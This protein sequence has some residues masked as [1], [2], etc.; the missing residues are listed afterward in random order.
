MK[1]STTNQNPNQHNASVSRRE[2]IGA[3]A[4]WGAALALGGASGICG[5]AHAQ[6]RS[7]RGPSG[8]AFARKVDIEEFKFNR[9]EIEI[10][11][12]K[13]FTV[14][15]RHLREGITTHGPNWK[16][17]RW[18]LF[19]PENLPGD[20]KVPLV[21]FLHGAGEHGDDNTSQMKHQ[22]PMMF[23]QPGFQAE[24]PCYFLAPQLEAGEV[25][26][27][28]NERTP[29][30][31]IEMLVRALAE[32]LEKWPLIDRQRIYGV[33]LS[34]G[35]GGCWDAMSKLPHL[36]AASLIMGGVHRPYAVRGDI[37]GAAWLCYNER[38]DARV[39]EQGDAMLEEFA[40]RGRP[41]RRS[42]G[43]GRSDHSS[44]KWALYQPGLVDWLWQQHLGYRTRLGEEIPPLMNPLFK[45]HIWLPK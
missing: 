45:K 35:G 40:K 29:A 37:R 33:G 34:T 2:Y 5:R 27:V 14:G 21:V 8:P 10:G 4:R 41:C 26:W 1:K 32:V 7:E 43:L 22:Q 28:L 11:L 39:R 25:W 12:E 30:P 42:V 6:E 16:P 18:R 13:D 23:V 24:R 3:A 31:G 17:L 20:T 9:N 44:W 15:V 38:E 36:F 19:R